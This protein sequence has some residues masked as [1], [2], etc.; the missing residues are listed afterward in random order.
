[1]TGDEVLLFDLDG[2]LVDSRGPIASCLNR[3]L[4][5]MGLAP[6]D[7]EELHALIGPPLREA[8]EILLEREEDSAELVDRCAAAYRVHYAAASVKETHLGPG[9]DRMLEA[10]AHRRLAVATSK[11][12]A[13]TLPILEA[14][15]VLDR[16]EHVEGPD[17]ES[18]NESKAVTLGRALRALGVEGGRGVMIGDRQHDVEAGRRHGLVTVGVVW[19]WGIGGAEEL[20]RAG[21]DHLVD[22]PA[23][24]AAL[25]GGR[26]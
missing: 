8:F 14:V 6:R 26:R 10:L 15:G 25:C 24:L 16:F 23:A 2:C 7:E 20:R 9:V 22:S 5:D 4:A 12:L 21:V 18:P 17:L 3:A 11:P 13:F 19:E 1:V